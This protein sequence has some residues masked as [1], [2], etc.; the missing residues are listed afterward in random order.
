MTAAGPDADWLELTT[1]PLSVDAAAVWVQLPGCGAVVTFSGTVRDH[2]DGRP[3]VTSIEYEA[4]EAYVE[5]RLGAVVAGAR[6]RW[7]DLG[8]IALLHRVGTLSVG[9]TSVVVAVSAPHR[10]EAFDAARFCIDELK[11]TV[12]LWK[13]E[14]W[15]GG[16]S[17]VRCDHEP[18]T[19][20]MAAVER[21][22]A[23]GG[24]AR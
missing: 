24:G 13:R 2:S 15:S 19:D 23:V 7:S 22:A 14:T 18:V 16:S 3:G 9:E 6:N 17:W 5:P 12:P 1:G 21:A 8:R 10:A 20:P 11:A 4:Y